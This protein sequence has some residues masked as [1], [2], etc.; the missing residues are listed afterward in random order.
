[1]KIPE[2]KIEEV[3]SA[4]DIV[5]VISTY[6][7]LKR[8]GKSYVGLCPFHKE[9]TPSFHV[10]PD[11]QMFYC[12]GCHEGGNVFTFVMRT[13][14]V[15]FVEAVRTL[16]N[17]AG[18]ELPVSDTTQPGSTQNEKLFRAN[19]VAARF[20]YHS[21]TQTT[22]G[23]Y[24]LEY[25]RNR[26]FRD[27]TIK[28]FG[29]GYALRSWQALVDHA[30]ETGIEPEH[31]EKAGL[32]GKRDDN[33]MYDRFRGRAMFP[34]FST[35]GRVVA[36]A[37]RQLYEDDSSINVG[38]KYINTPETLIYHK[39]KLLYGLSLTRDEIRKQEYAILVEGYTDLIS[40]Y[41]AGIQNVVASSGTA[42]TEEQIR[43]LGRYA[44]SVVIVYDADSAGSAAA[45]RGVELL[46]EKGLDVKIV[47]LPEGEDPDS[48]VRS[49][50]K[51]VFLDLIDE[52]VS[53]VDFKASEL[54]KEGLFATP[55][56][57][58]R[59]VRSIIETLAKIPDELKR[60]FYIKAI[61]E[62]YDLY[63]ST[64]YRELDSI[65][66]KER[67]RP[68]YTE[69]DEKTTVAADTE[70]PV[71]QNDQS[72]NTVN[73][74]TSAERD[75][76]KLIMQSDREVMEFIFSQVASDEMQ[77]PVAR[78]LFEELFEHYKKTGNTYAALL[79]NDDSF[80]EYSSII[81][82]LIAERYEVSERWESLR[83]F[84]DFSVNM[85]LSIDAVRTLKKKNIKERIE[86]VRKNIREVERE[87][88]DSI[89]L[90][91]DLQILQ[92][93]L[94]LLDQHYSTA[95]RKPM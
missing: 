85:Q 71:N 32:A 14:K 30:Q 18:I 13:E 36:F 65:T 64:L 77:H 11:K 94:K 19:M 4:S 80:S 88:G 66:R 69:P 41:Q 89:T 40:M 33:T 23:N 56:G 83:G 86:S 78:K 20:F 26:G 87:G 68:K 44:P 73:S 43:L 25:F 1:M 63:E 5:D 54:Q 22:E 10:T 35:S 16:A 47:Q 91:R 53:F 29:L 82:Q 58:A 49:Q 17:R 74:F 62:R 84:E 21:L 51:N 37:G 28:Q 48:F 81:T 50:G 42:L 70:P 15:S 8:R 52:S 9:K 45:L 67:R 95:T 55:E 2:D 12:F 61:A 39:S 3:R 38:A 72:R 27:E 24:A 79:I 60:N 7:R 90:A 34:I 93:E 46:L 59:A 92:Q 57:Q 75:I 76:L 31:L 6:V